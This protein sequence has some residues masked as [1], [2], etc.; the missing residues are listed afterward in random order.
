[1]GE[2]GGY[3]SRKQRGSRNFQQVPPGHANLVYV[4]CFIAHDSTFVL[5]WSFLVLLDFGFS[6]AKTI[7]LRDTER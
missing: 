3:G 6:M 4:F 7:A 2:Q 5:R 1:M